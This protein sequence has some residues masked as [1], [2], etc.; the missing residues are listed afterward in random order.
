[1]E[2]WTEKYLSLLGVEKKE[3]D[4][5]YLQQLAET[6]LHRVPFE[7][8]SK[9]YYFSNKNQND[10]IPSKEEY[11]QNFLEK[12][13][14][15]NCYIL[16]IHF[17]KLLEDLGFDV[18]IVR[19]RGGNSHLA[20]MVTFDNQSYYTDVGY[21]APFFEPLLLIN[22]PYI[23][24]CGEEII[25]KQLSRKEFLIDR[26][27]GGQSFVTKTIEW[28]PVIL[29][30]FN[31]DIL[32]SHR[33]EDDNPF[34]RRITAAIFKKRVSYTLMNSK[35]IVKSDKNISVRDFDNK[36][37]WLGEVESTFNLRKQDLEFAL[38]FLEE[39]NVKLF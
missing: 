10:L 32:H 23:V 18:N 17:G 37:E 39:R 19:A 30:S 38:D 27:T 7:I 14:G 4:Y 31:G 34:M 24:R 28:Y 29:D 15:G 33:D 11:L 1:M 22:E 36:N 12:G 3:P 16:N 8:I 20:L 13:W 2:K 35:I 26:R 5:Q 6:H 9:F 21:M 25:I